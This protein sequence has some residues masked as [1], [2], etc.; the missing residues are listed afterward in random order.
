MAEPGALVLDV[1]GTR[2]DRRSG[3]LDEARALGPARTGRR[4]STTGIGPTSL[5]TT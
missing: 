4:S 5:R 2:V 3:L 1:F